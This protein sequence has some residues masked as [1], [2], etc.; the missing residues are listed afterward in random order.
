MTS[1]PT[2]Q[3]VVEALR[4]FVSSVYWTEEAGRVGGDTGGDVSRLAWLLVRAGLLAEDP[5]VPGWYWVNWYLNEPVV[6]RRAY[7][8]GRTWYDEIACV[9]ANIVQPAPPPSEE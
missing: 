8:D 7:W 9:P 1:K 5:V 6:F 3:Q 4:P 2:K